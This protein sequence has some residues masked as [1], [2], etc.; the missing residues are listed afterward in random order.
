MYGHWDEF[1]FNEN[2]ADK[3][4]AIADALKKTQQD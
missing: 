3:L 4:H 2:D 1:F